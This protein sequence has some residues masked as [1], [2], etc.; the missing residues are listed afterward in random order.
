VRFFYRTHA[1]GAAVPGHDELFGA[2]SVSIHHTSV[3]A[4]A[5]NAASGTTAAGATTAWAGSFSV[6]DVV[7][8]GVVRDFTAA[9]LEVTATQ[10][11]RSGV[12][13]A[14]YQPYGARTHR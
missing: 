10:G 1:F 14:T 11:L 13:P 8:P 12:E 2:I 4:G 9:K 3:A 7:M 5:T 6:V